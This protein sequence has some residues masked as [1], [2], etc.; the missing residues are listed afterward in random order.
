MYTGWVA[1]VP[2]LL[3]CVSLQVCQ[4]VCQ[5]GKVRTVVWQG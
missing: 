4:V 2:L 5:A 3:L 1:G